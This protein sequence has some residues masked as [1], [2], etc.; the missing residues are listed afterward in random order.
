MSER[1]ESNKAFIEAIYRKRPFRGHAFVCHPKLIP[2]HEH[3]DYFFT[4]SDKPVDNW[5][6]QFAENYRRQQV[7]LE[8]VG[9]DSVPCAK[10]PTGTHIYAAAFG[11][12]VHCHEGSP[13][14][15][16]PFVGSAREA[17]AL[18]QPD[19][20]KSPTL[21]R[22]FEMAER[23]TKEVGPDAYL[24]PPDMQSGFDTAALV[25]D[26]TDFLCAMA[27]EREKASVKRLVAKCAA[28]FKAF[29]VAFR[30]EFPNCVP[31]HCPLVWTPPEMG[32]WLSND[33]CGAMSVDMF[34]EFCLPELIDLSQTFGGLGMHCCANA[35]H[36]FES[37]K[38]IPNFYA[39]NRVAPD[40]RYDTLPACFP[41]P[42]APVFVLAWM[43]DDQLEA[44]LRTAHPQT[45]FI[46]VRN[47]LTVD[48]AREWLDSCRALSPR[49]DG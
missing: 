10:I 39:F 21:Y 8:A 7:M 31:S 9:S 49:K 24:G 13:P 20:W 35:E 15:A 45:R 19:L 4:T 17:D 14:C 47:N 5:I 25:W 11:C 40:R 3:P 18:D 26:K 43:P 30:R 48:E 28:L 37:F 42:D 16:L 1:I 46:F 29:L 33:E 22:L 27:D 6:P 36:Q 12:K 32:P 38:K 41:E 34:E 23:L 44:L 2:A